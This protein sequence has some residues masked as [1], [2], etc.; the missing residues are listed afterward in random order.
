MGFV[1]GFGAHGY[2]TPTSASS[3]PVINCNTEGI[4]ILAKAHN[5]RLQSL[6]KELS[7]ME[8]EATSMAHIESNQQ[9]YRDGAERIRKDVAQ[10]TTD[11]QVAVAALNKQCSNRA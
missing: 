7:T 4:A 10:E 6:R 3:L 5:E 9:V 1:A 11:F 8:A 2:L